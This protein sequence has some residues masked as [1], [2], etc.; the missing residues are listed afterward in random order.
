MKSFPQPPGP[1]LIAVALSLIAMTAGALQ[2]ADSQV[3][4]FLRPIHEINL[5]SAESGVVS[6]ILVKPGDKVKQGQ[7]ILRLNSTVIEAQLA[8]AEAQALNEG[9]LKSA[10][11]EYQISKQRL[12]ILETLRSSGSTI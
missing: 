8:Q 6:T 12:A 11:A 3:L 4:T 5:A 10:E 1:A 9:R 2:A 7:E